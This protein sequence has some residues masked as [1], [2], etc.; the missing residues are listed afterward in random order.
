LIQVC[1]ASFTSTFAT[2]SPATMI[3]LLMDKFVMAMYETEAFLKFLIAFIALLSVHCA[4]KKAAE[5]SAAF[6]IA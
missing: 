6:L 3:Y 5:K 1:R 2:A 4:R